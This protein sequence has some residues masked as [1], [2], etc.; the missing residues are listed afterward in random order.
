M[1]EKMAEAPPSRPFSPLS[2]NLDN[3]TKY[4]FLG[5]VVD[6]ALYE[7]K[8]LGSKPPLGGLSTNP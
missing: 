4:G 1:A 8:V 6:L 7:T 3:T 2:L 5:R